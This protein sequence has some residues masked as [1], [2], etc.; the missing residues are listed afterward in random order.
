MKLEVCLMQYRD[1]YETLGVPKNAS[2]DDI[3]KSY[4]KLA[5]KYH[6]D[7]NPGNK[8]AEEKFKGISEAYEVLGD[9][10]KRKK[11]DTFGQN[12]NFRNGYDFDP[13]QY[14]FG[15]NVKYDY[16]TGGSGGFSDFFNMF[17][18]GGGINLNGIFSGAGTKAGRSARQPW[19]GPQRGQDRE[20]AIDITP[21]QGFAGVEKRISIQGGGG[22]KT[23]SFKV[24]A[25]IKD[26]EKIK[27]G[28]QGLSGVN[29]GSDGDLY[30][31][32]RIKP[33][34]RFELDGMN[35]TTSLEVYPWE[36]ALG[37]EKAV[38]ILDG[39]IAVKVPPGIQTDNKIRVPGKGYIDRTGNRGDLHIR[40]RIVNPKVLTPEQRELYEKL[41]K[42]C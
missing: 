30:L 2:Q 39:R 26:G 7:A 31:T 14:G 6:P 13:S 33:G 12:A 20:A 25:G 27:L 18:G 4:R 37:A 38:D 29:G 36:A 24:P 11:Y 8:E 23:V 9:T 19:A 34:S 1:Y 21:E 42:T 5:K 22:E 32:V 35:V 10:E 16:K 15:K 40:I 3:K 28:G 41:M 17:F